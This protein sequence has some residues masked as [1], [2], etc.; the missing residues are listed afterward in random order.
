MPRARRS[1]ALG[2]ALTLALALSPGCATLPGMLTGAFTGAVDA[3]MEVYRHHRVL[4]DRHPIYWPFNVLFFV[5]L[6]IAAGPLVGMAKGIALDIQWLL[7]QRSYP[8][9]FG[10]YS[11]ESIWRPYTITW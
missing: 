2:L 3:P 11:E 8:Q 6:G 4:F 1:R 5:P 9:V 10:S 7:G